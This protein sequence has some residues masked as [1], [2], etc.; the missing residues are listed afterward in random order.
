MFFIQSLG[1]VQGAPGGISEAVIG[2]PLQGC[3]IVEERG[4]LARPLLSVADMGGAAVFEIINNAG[5][6]MAVPNTI[7][8]V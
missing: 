5:G 1:Q 4:N 3:K 2:F 8:F 7:R 6:S